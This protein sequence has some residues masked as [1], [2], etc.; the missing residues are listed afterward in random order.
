M[1]NNFRLFYAVQQVGLAEDGLPTIGSAHTVHGLQSFG[2]NTNFNLTQVFEMGQ[3]QIYMNYEDIPNIEVTLEKA[4]D[5][6]CPLYLL[7]TLK[8]STAS[9]S[10]RSTVKCGVA[11][12]VFS[13]QQDASSG[14]PISKVYMSGMF[15]SAVSWKF[16]VDGIFTESLTLVGNNKY[17]DS[18]IGPITFNGQFTTNADVPLAISNSGSVQHR[19]DFIWAPLTSGSTNYTILPPDIN[20]ISSSGTN[21]KDST[22]NYNAAVQSVTVSSNFGRE[23]LYQLGQKIPYFRYLTFPIEVKTDVEIIAKK[24]DNISATDAG[25]NSDCSN[26]TARQIVIYVREGTLLNLGT[27]NKL[28][29]VQYGGADAKQGSKG[30][31][32]YSFAGFNFLTV[33]HPQDPSH[34]V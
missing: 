15:P 8:G 24:L 34:L 4:L 11:A 30:T 17:T 2:V 12:A 33:T 13:D 27:Q 3:N 9:L 28:A 19:Q 21:D 5:G 6:Y 20:G 7:A 29:S 10:G 26:L 18:Y 1:A 22:G 23:P 16:P 32:T 14:T 25:I 31:I